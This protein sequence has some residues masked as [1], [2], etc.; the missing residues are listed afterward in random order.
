MNAKL[1]F[2]NN[3]ITITNAKLKF[4]NTKIKNRSAENLKSNSKERHHITAVSRNGEARDLLEIGK[5]I[6]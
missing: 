6:N 2:S 1:T 5:V 3:K 4:I